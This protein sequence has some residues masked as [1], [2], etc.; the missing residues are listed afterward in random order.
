MRTLV[1]EEEG[2]TLTPQ[3][4]ALLL[5]PLS[6]SLFPAQLHFPLSPPFFL[7]L[8]LMSTQDYDYDC[9]HT[10]G[11]HAPLCLAG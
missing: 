9:V 10:A 7:V 2:L 6:I 1:A 3:P 5:H 4:S 8:A 11:P